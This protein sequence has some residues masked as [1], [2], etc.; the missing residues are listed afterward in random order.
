MNIKNLLLGTVLGISC[1]SSSAPV[2]AS[3]SEDASSE[4][5]MPMT[6]RLLEST[7]YTPTQVA[8]GFW[9]TRPPEAR[10]S[11]R[12]SINAMAEDANPE[13]QARGKAILAEIDRLKPKD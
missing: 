1:F 11:F 10:E 3:A 2:C 4:L 9:Y 6:G 8:E 13:R 7:E 12:P 5:Q